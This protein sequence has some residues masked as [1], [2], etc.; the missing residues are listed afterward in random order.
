M[1]S[2]ICVKYLQEC[3]KSSYCGCKCWLITNPT[4]GFLNYSKSSLLI[5]LYDVHIN[6]IYNDLPNLINVTMYYYIHLLCIYCYYVYSNSRWSHV[7]HV[8]DR[9]CPNRRAIVY[10]HISYNIS[11]AV[12]QYTEKLHCI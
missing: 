6:H 4:K 1:R 12:A 5:Y 10:I 2:S 7:C 9:H 8:Q 11:F 3:L